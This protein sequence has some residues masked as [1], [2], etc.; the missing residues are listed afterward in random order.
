MSTRVSTHALRI[1]LITTAVVAAVMVALCIAVDVIVAH[2]L[3]ASATT[4]LTSELALLAHKPGGPNLDEP[5]V[6]DLWERGGGCEFHNAN[7]DGD[8]FGAGRAGGSGGDGVR[9]F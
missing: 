6:D 3:R 2:T 9:R 8:E 1:A 4:R 7:G 5:D